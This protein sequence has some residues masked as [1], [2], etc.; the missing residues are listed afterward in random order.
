MYPPKEKADEKIKELEIRLEERTEDR[1]WYR[2]EIKDVLNKCAEAQKKE[3]QH[4]V[5]P[6]R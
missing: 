2:N 5:E 3:N 4:L 6:N 1:A